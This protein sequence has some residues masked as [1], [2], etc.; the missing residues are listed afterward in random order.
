MTG[1]ATKEWIGATPDSPVPPRVRLRI[2]ERHNGICHVSGRKIMPGDV[3]DLDHI[4]ALCNGGENRESNLALALVEPHKH[5]T[6]RDRAAKKKDDRVR[7][8]HY[9][10]RN[11]KQPFRGW[12]RFDGSPV[13]NPKAETRRAR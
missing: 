1:R 11:P 5:K 2:F 13:R 3:W 4:V 10:I 12:R 8:R 6:R 9:G 7:K